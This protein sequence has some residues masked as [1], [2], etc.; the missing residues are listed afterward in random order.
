MWNFRLPD[1]EMQP[2]SVLWGSAA[3]PRVPP[4]TYQVKL[5]M[6]E[7]SQTREFEVLEI[8]YE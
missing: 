2:K 6:G 7:W 1:G 8:R 4:G 5:T 3:G